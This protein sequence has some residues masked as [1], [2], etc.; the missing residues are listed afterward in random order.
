MS[1]QPLVISLNTLR[2]TKDPHGYIYKG[3][4]FLLGRYNNKRLNTERIKLFSVNKIIY[5]NYFSHHA[6]CS[7]G[8]F[9]SNF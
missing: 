3:F 9:F 4:I 8:Q 2:F 6:W 7:L 1:F 5:D